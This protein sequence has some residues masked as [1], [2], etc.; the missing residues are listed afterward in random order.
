MNV[1]EKINLKIYN[2]ELKEIYN[3]QSNIITDN[4]NKVVAFLANDID[5]GIY[6]YKVYAFGNN[7]DEKTGKII[8]K[9]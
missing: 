1:G 9:K 3:I 7:K 4:K 6:I 8:V 2:I 5:L